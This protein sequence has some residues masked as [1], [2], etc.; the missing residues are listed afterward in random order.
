MTRDPWLQGRD[1]A[2]RGR[3]PLPGGLQELSHQEHEA[4]PHR[5]W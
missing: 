4:Q 2:G 5:G 3:V 1:A